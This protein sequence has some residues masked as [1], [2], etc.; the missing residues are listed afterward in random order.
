MK[1][2][3]LKPLFP[4]TLIFLL[5]LCSCVKFSGADDGVLYYRLSNHSGSRIRVVLYDFWGHKYYSNSQFD[6]TVYYNAGEERDL[7]V[8][9]NAPH[10]S[11][12]PEYLDTLQGIR[13]LEIYKDDTTPTTINYRERRYW[14][15]SE[16]NPYKH[17]YSVEITDDSFKP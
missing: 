16:I 17:E 6:S 5:F 7:L 12:E 13:V 15:Y 10:W 9:Y 3:I 1:S 8:V 14:S 2:P 11:Q 4:L